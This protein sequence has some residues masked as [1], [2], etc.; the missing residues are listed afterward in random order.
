MFCST[1]A[2]SNQTATATISNHIIMML[3]AF[4]PASSII[5]FNW[6]PNFK[7]YTFDVLII[8]NFFLIFLLYM[9]CIARFGTICTSFYVFVLVHWSLVVLCLFD[10]KSVISTQDKMWKRGVTNKKKRGLHKKGGW[11]PYQLLRNVRHL[12]SGII[13]ELIL[14]KPET[15]GPSLFWPT[16]FEMQMID[17][18]R[19]Y[20][21]PL[22]K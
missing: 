3:L 7:M 1:A 15:S 9:W 11:T 4:I 20:I 5:V 16:S 19:F 17:L 12:V 2:I 18:T 13:P 6:G 22:R 10:T 8:I 21:F 14:G